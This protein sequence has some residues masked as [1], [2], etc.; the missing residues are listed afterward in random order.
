MRFCLSLNLE[1]NEFP[2]DYRRVILSY[3]KNAISNCNN[4]KYYDSYFKDTIQKDYCFSVVLPKPKYTKDKILI[5]NK[6]IKILFSTDDKK[7]TGFIL[8]SAFISQKNR[9]FL[10]PNNNS[11]TLKNISNQKD[12]EITNSKVIFKTSK[13]SGL[14][15]RDH[16][17]ETNMDTHYIF[18]D[19]KFQE[20]FKV[21]L[22]NQAIQAGF[23]D[24]EV[25]SIKF[26]PIQCKKV[27]AK[28]YR[29][30]IDTTVGMFEMQGNSK[31]LQYFYNAGIGSRKSAGFGMIDLVTQD[32]L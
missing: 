10:I 11:M 7:K 5:E 26:N 4:G 21:V 12:Q 17:K 3:I 14:C 8:F 25:E 18:N 2:L 16:N 15:V 29:S 28:H 30:Y 9:S 20:K 23:S 22:K 6:E 24:H 27:V 13:G 1:K 32:L 31:L 19:E